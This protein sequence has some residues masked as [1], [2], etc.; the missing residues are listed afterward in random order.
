[1]VCYNDVTYYYV[2]G[3]TSLIIKVGFRLH[4]HLSLVIRALQYS[5]LET[6]LDAQYLT[7]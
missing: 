2:T 1:M 7:I 5:F 4:D 3:Q 6:E